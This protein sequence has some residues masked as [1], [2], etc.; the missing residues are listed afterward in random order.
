MVTTPLPRALH[1]A[2]AF[3]Q[4]FTAAG[5]V[6]LPLSGALLIGFDAGC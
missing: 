2:N 4:D 6:E 3:D 1:A 5:F